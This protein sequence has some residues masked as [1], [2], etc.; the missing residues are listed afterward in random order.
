MSTVRFDP[1]FRTVRDLDR[2]T[3]ELLAAAAALRRNTTSR[4]RARTASPSRW[5]C[6]ATTSTSSRSAA[7]DRQL[8]VKGEPKGG[9]WA[10]YIRRGI[11]RA[12]FQRSF[13]LGE[14]IEVAGARRSTRASCVELER[15]VPEAMKP[16]TISI[17]ALVAGQPAAPAAVEQAA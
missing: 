11:A 8:V 13:T 12:S 4:T 7:K 9:N 16:R 15:R 14:H 17:A 2:M 3:D 6:P 10:N 5:L 1:F